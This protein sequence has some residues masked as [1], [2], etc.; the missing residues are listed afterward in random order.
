MP[1]GP[2]PA[3]V[4]VPGHP[5]LVIGAGFS[6]TLTVVHLLRGPAP[7]GMRILW[8][9]REPPFGRGLAYR[10]WDDNQLLNVPAGNMSALPDE[11]AH[12]LAWCR[13][14]DPAL[15]AGSFVP[16]RLYGDYLQQLLAAT[17]Q[18][19]PAV[20]Q[21]VAGEAVALLPGGPQRGF[22]A[23]LH[24]GRQVPA[25]QVVLALGHAPPAWP[26][27]WSGPSDRS[28]SSDG[29]DQPDRPTRPGLAALAEDARCIANPWQL[30][31]LDALPQGQPVLLL[32]TGHTAVD[33]LF[34]LCSAGP[35]PVWMLSRRG[36]LPQAHRTATAA[37]VQRPWP[38]WL[39]GVPLEVRPLLRAVRTEA[40]RCVA[41]G[42]DWRDA[43]NELRP[44]TPALWQ[45]LSLAQQR[46]FLRR[47][48]PWWDVHRHRLAPSAH[49][50]L[51][52]LRADGHL[53]VLAG[54][55]M[56]ASTDADGLHLHV[57]VQDRGG[58]AVQVL[59][60]AAV[61]NCSG[62]QTD[63]RAQ[64]APLVQQLLAQGWL[65]PDVLRQGLAFDA[66]GRALGAGGQPVPGLHVIG[67]VLKARFWEATAVPELRGHAAR[68]A[69]V[70]LQAVQQTVGDSQTAGQADQSGSGVPLQLLSAAGI[71]RLAA[72]ATTD[73]RP[74]AKPSAPWVSTP[75]VRAKAPTNA[76]SDSLAP[77]A[78]F[79]P[80]PQPASCP[81]GLATL[82]VRLH[83]GDDLRR[84]IEAA[85]QAQGLAGGF[86]V[87]GIGSLRPALIRLAGAE[88]SL[89]L[90]QDLEL[91]SL[92]GSVAAGHSH[93]HA[94]VSL[95]DGRVLGGHVAYG[96]T[97]RTTA[98][99][100]LA[101]LPTWQLSREPDP[102]TG[103]AEL[104]VRPV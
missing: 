79:A 101:L 85:V 49:Q 37:P 3:P 70:V 34:R 104:V 21:R 78:G 80:V 58:G 19:H 20:L 5:V 7:P 8:L 67:P 38:A 9:E 33:V 84:G 42:G 82:P 93:L 72:D 69:G 15:N 52:Q 75:A 56:D 81:P 2:D 23:Q 102:A 73:A 68:L 39:A 62:P 41:Q 59:H 57:H 47:L 74:A 97:V 44:H 55:L 92:S 87:A 24:D 65:Q 64:A 29:S 25:Q 36:L 48:R 45:A 10:T 53:Q 35:R 17:E 14:G 83:P 13:Q 91:L 76:L 51:G 71:A 28:D 12:F 4:V 61:V 88:H 16:R 26:A 27:E 90:D 31:A 100:L 63:V 50:R 30:A 1:P 6:G 32:G 11:P 60:V 43:M 95:P 98:E 46:R 54:R 77:A 94:S 86:V 103:Y 96:C 89:R 18:A 99:L 22:V 66:D 40:A